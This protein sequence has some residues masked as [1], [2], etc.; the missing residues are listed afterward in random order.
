MNHS[1]DH[2]SSD[3]P[4]DSDTPHPVALELFQP[5][6]NSLYSL[7][8]AARLARVPRRSILVYC[9]AGLIQP[10]LLP[11]YGAMAFTEETIRVVRCVEYA[12][13][14]HRLDLAWIKTLFGLL[15]EVERLRAELRFAQA[16]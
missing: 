13:T 10:V 5:Q 9:R 6:P 8:M 3:H 1:S 12:R 11:P 16:R 7:E 14:V 2:F 4:C 15:D